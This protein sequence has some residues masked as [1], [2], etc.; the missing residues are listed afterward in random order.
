MKLI[1]E[2]WR[3]YL[4]EYVSGAVGG[5]STTE[6]ESIK[7]KFP[8]LRELDS[9]AVNQILETVLDPS[10]KPMYLGPVEEFSP[11]FLSFLKS[12]GLSIAEAPNAQRCGKNTIVFIGV[13]EN[14]EKAIELNNNPF[15][16]KE[17]LNFENEFWENEEVSRII[18]AGRVFEGFCAT[19]HFHYQMGVLLGYGKD[20]SAK[21]AGKMKKPWQELYDDFM[22]P[23]RVQ[24][25]TG[26]YDDDAPVELL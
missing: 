11:N 10:K 14:V 26:A 16:G 3:K 6:K 1:M 23:H 15:I 19:P 5:Q 18:T 7:Q 9:M 2:N 22:Q 24:Q 25:R 13:P 4:A 20:N 12:K 17:E 21:F 8:E